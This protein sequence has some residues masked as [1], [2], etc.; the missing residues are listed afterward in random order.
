MDRYFY[1]VFKNNILFNLI[2]VCIM[3]FYVLIFGYLKIRGMTIFTFDENRLTISEHFSSKKLAYSEIKNYAL[4]H[5]GI[6][7][8]GSILRIKTN[9]NIFY[10][11]V[12]NRINKFLQSDI[13]NYNNIQKLL[14]E[15]LGN[16]K[17]LKLIDYFITMLA[18]LPIV[19][20]IGSI[21]FAII[22]FTIIYK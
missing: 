11:I 15:K 18:F 13:D 14:I 12:P 16:K 8:W 6:Q 22:Y 1:H 21:I 7:K 5:F 10:F 20:L 19:L 9:K 3:F 2:E 17:R 4:Y